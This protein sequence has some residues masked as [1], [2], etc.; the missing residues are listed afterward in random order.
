MSKPQ[1]PSVLAQ[2]KHKHHLISFT[3]LATINDHHS[4]VENKMDSTDTSNNHEAEPGQARVLRPKAPVDIEKQ[5][6]VTLASGN[7]CARSLTCTR[8]G[9]SAKRAVP[10][11]SAPFDQLLPGY[12]REN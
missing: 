4:F 9:M 7:Q 12:R 2:P 10:G 3:T 6:A 8:H 1:G 5:C 11:R